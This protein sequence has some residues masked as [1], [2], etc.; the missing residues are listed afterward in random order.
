MLTTLDLAA[1]KTSF[2]APLVARLL[3]LAVLLGVCLSP[4]RG[5]AGTPPL[6][7]PAAI[8]PQAAPLFALSLD[9]VFR[10]IERV[11]SSRTRMIQMAVLGMCLG[12]W[13]LMRR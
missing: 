3:L 2:P 7:G 6:E 12:L 8:A 1:M 5:A 11:L 13:I 10:P 4:G 9:T